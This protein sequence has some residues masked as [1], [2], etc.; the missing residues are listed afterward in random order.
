M[1]DTSSNSLSSCKRPTLAL[2]MPNLNKYG[3]L[4]PL[5]ILGCLFGQLPPLPASVR[6]YQV[7]HAPQITEAGLVVNFILEAAGAT[8]LAT[9]LSD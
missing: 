6:S 8:L 2:Q 1:S 4:N 5:M 7:D 9:P 3:Q